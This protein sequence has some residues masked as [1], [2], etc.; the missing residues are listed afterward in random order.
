MKSF[1]NNKNK[2]CL[3]LKDDVGGLRVK[4]H[5]RLHNFGS[6]N[7]SVTIAF[8]FGISSNKQVIVKSYLQLGKKPPNSIREEGRK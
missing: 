2:V 4:S 7:Y 3:L 5:T 6:Y 8:F 1:D